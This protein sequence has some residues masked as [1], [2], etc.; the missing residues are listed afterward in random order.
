MNASSDIGLG[1]SS[2]E[3]PVVVLLSTFQS[4]HCLHV[5]NSAYDCRRVKLYPLSITP[6]DEHFYG[7]NYS[8]C[9]N[10]TFSKFSP[11]LQCTVDYVLLGQ[12][13]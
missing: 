5:N 7:Y 6:I 2:R 8:F 1:V 13:K 4:P 3:P 10:F 11:K 12:D 9:M